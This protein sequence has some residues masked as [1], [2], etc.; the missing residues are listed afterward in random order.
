[1][2]VQTEGNFFCRKFYCFVKIGV[3]NEKKKYY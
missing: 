3:D 1:M 2:F